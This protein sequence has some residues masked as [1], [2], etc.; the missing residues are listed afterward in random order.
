MGEK[1]FAELDALRG[2]AA[3]AV[4]LY[5]FREH[6]ALPFQGYPLRFGRYGVQ[7]FFCISG[8]VIFWTLARTPRLIDFAFSRYSRL[9][10]AY[11]AA[12]ALCALAAALHGQP[13]SLAEYAANATMLE[14]F[15]GVP[16]VDTVF[17]TL[18]IELVFYVWMATFFAL[19]LGQKMAPLAG[20]WLALSAATAIAARVWV[21]PTWIDTYFLV[22]SIPFFLGGVAFYLISVE[23]WKRTYVAV[24]GGA[25]VVAGLRDWRELVVASLIFAAFAAAIAGRL[26]WIVNPVTGWL[27]AISYALYL[28]HQRVVFSPDRLPGWATLLAMLG[29]AFALASIVTYGIERPAMARLRAWYKRRKPLARAEGVS[30]ANE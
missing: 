4:V 14:T 21:L 7:L 17:W 13:L 30:S 28:T 10:P 6:L 24:I 27:G 19:G 1:R 18:A 22:S 2:F 12:L 20:V 5:H 15:L 26:R 16:Y 25:M 11:W 3:I 8:F 29:C 23:G 9:Y